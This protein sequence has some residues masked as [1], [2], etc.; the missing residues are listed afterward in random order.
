MSM[1]SWQVRIV[2]FILNRY[3]TIMRTYFLGTKILPLRVVIC[4]SMF[5]PG[6]SFSRNLKDLQGFLGTRDLNFRRKM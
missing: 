1:E 4:Y 5:L 2:I 3:V 6:A